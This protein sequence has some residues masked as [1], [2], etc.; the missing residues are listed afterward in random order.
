MRAAVALYGGDL[1][2]GHDEPWLRPERD[3][4]RGRHLDALG[5]LADL[6]EA[7]GDLAEA[8]THA[9]RLLRHDPLREEGYRRL[10]RLHAARGDAA[11]ALGVY[12]EC[13]RLLESEL[14]VAP[15]AATR[16]AYAA[17]LPR[18]APGSGE[19]VAGPPPLVGRAAER[20]RLVE[21]WRACVAGRTQFVLLTGE[22]GIGKSRLAE[23]FRAWC[24]RQGAVV[25]EA[26]CHAAEGPLVYGP[27][28]AWLRSGA[29]RPRLAQ[30]DRESRSEL[31]RL[32]PELL[33]E[34]PDTPKP[35][36]LPADEQRRRLLEAVADAVLAGPA[37]R[38]LVLDD[39]QHADRETCRL[40]HFLIRRDPAARLVVVATA[41]R[42]EIDRDHPVQEL[43]A[44]LDALERYAEIELG[45]LDRA[46]T[47]VLARRLTGE[48]VD[49]ERL[50]AETEGNPLFVV[51]ALRVG[52]RQDAPVSR[53][54]QTVLETRLAQL[55]GTA[56][57]LAE[58]AATIGREFRV[59]VLA[60]A[61]GG[62]DEALLRGLDEL[63]RRRILREHGGEVYRFSHDKIREVAVLGVSPPRRRLLHLR[64]AP[65]LERAYAADPG[66]VSAQIAAHY[67]EGGSPG[68][69]V[70][71]YRRAAEAAQELHASRIGRRPP[72]AGGAPAPRAAPVR[73]PRRGRA[74]SWRTRSSARSPRWWA[75]PP[76]P[77]RPTRRRRTRLTRAV[78]VPLAPPL[79]RSLGMT[80]LTREDFP[81]TLRIGGEL[82]AAG[83]QPRRRRARRRGRLPPGDGGVLAGRLRRRPHA[84]GDRRRPLPARRPRHPSRPL[85]PG[86]QGGVPGPPRQHP[87]VPRRPRRRAAGPR[88]RPRLGRGDRAAVQHRHRAA[89]RRDAGPRHGRRAR[90]APPH[91]PAGGDRAEGAARSASPPPRWPDISTCSTGRRRSGS[92]PSTTAI[93]DAGDQGPAP[94][95]PAMLA[96]IRLGAAVAGNEPA[97]AVAAADALLAMGGAAD[98]WAAA[99]RQARA[100]FRGA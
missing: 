59:D 53:R 88:R 54:V 80:A 58:V 71:W 69:A 99:A 94:G 32:L 78:G 75:T 90:P 29:L 79:L 1:L 3:R 92:P 18:E 91:R 48:P 49:I 35:E 83:E 21:L 96:R 60:A 84:P 87:L 30:L 74:G 77:S 72:G 98:V 62:D 10:M 50:F 43:L 63:W 81:A 46:E 4:L 14:G 61:A 9:E 64:I 51:E 22:A 66:P 82:Q 16:A 15:S 33:T 2:D 12:H 45:R 20:R 23:D 95:V 26:R 31:A 28:T 27:V 17:L 6:C 24:A 57:E 86:P 37:P 89:L 7:A 8:V 25:A 67:A 65:A 73:A 93:R 40:L 44:G 56:R 52:P 100:A 13:S 42:E 36:P 5:E 70:T 39:L 47:D 55:S 76:P 34:V 68:H 97:R 41:R 11:R 38:L 19:P 85:R